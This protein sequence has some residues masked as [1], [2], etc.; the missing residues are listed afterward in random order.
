M[1]RGPRGYRLFEIA[2][3]EIRLD[4]SWLFLGLLIAWTLAAGV[5]PA[6]YPDLAGSLYWAMG[7]ACAVG[8]LASIVFHELSHSLVARRYGL[9]MRGITLFIFG[10]MAEMAEE[11]KDPRTEFLMA[12]AGP[13]SS[14][15]LGAAF[16]GLYRLGTGMEAHP[17]WLGVTYYLGWINII[18]AVFNLVPAFPLDGGRMLRAALWRYGKDLR[19]AT[20][21]AASIGSGFGLVLIA[22]GV[23]G[24]IGGNFIGGL[25]YVLIGLF[26]RGAAR[27]SYQQVLVQ[28]FLEEMPVSRFMTPDPVTLAP[29][30]PVERAVEDY[31]FRHHHR[32]FPVVEGGALLGCLSADDVK[33]LPREAWAGTPVRDIM[34]PCGELTA[35]PDDDASRLLGA[36]AAPDGQT[37]RLVV[38]DAGQLVGVVSLKDLREHIALRLKLSPPEGG[39]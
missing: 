35:R 4:P 16:Y 31:F 23:I 30:L 27:M 10:G 5:F 36:M 34:R 1:N 32:L 2:G 28:E 17:F 37:R 21:I 7:A 38:D 13:V 19:N 3:F 8:I 39:D 24:I 33:K 11:A 12:V 29:D 25:W 22:L 20:R 6:R 14:L 26:L 9:P 15:V 18:L